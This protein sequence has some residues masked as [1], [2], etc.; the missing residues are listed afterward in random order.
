MLWIELVFHFI[1][2]SPQAAYIINSMTNGNKGLDLL[3]AILLHHIPKFSS[4]A[5]Y[6]K[7][8][9]DTLEWV[10]WMHL[11]AWR[12]PVCQC[13]CLSA[14]LPACLSVCLPACLPYPLPST[15]FPWQQCADSH[16]DLA[17]IVDGLELGISRSEFIEQ[18]DR[19]KYSNP[20]RYARIAWKTGASRE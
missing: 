12:L 15:T 5:T 9:A 3:E 6:S 14:C 4:K 1:F 2:P 16:R 13:D 11:V 17:D 18:T 7:T 20:E 10:K 8:D 19:R